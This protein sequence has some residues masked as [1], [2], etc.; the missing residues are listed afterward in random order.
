MK[1]KSWGKKKEKE[2]EQVSGDGRIFITPLKINQYCQCFTFPKK[3][4]FFFSNISHSMSFKQDVINVINYLRY[5]PDV[6]SVS[7]HGY[8]HVIRN[9]LFPA[10]NNAKRLF[11]WENPIDFL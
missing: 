2:A 7:A 3:I 8:A 6:C 4:T 10:Q 11:V 1:K 9:S 5:E